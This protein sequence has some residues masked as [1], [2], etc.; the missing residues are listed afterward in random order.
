MNTPAIQLEGIRKHQGAFNLGPLD[1]VIPKGAVYGLVGPNGA[2]KTTTLDLLMGLGQPDTGR[3]R[4]LGLDLARDE[5]A[6]K[7]RVAYVGPDLNYQAWGRVGRTM[8]FF[9]GFYPDWDMGR[10]DRLLADFGLDRAE[11]LYTLSFGARTKLALVLALS[12]DAELLLLDE[13]TTGLDPIAR[14]RLFEE[15]LGYMRRADRTVVISSHQLGD[16]ERF[17]DH[18][19]I[20]HRGLLVAEGRM[21]VLVDRYAQWNVELQ[22]QATALPSCLRVLSRDG[23]RARV[24]ADLR[25]P[26]TQAAREALLVTGEAPMTL[27]EVFLGLVGEA[28]PEEP[29]RAA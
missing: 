25:A 20:L 10:A 21:D 7:R 24:M 22:A 16:L 12:R 26:Q 15:L 27:E 3:I 9:A 19:G 4:M 17:A 11:R 1:L 6:V 18:I 29:R 8:D 13:P 28:R 2:G 5:V 14:R 23:R